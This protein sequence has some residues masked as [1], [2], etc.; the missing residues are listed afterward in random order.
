MDRSSQ[1]GT[2]TRTVAHAVTAA[3]YTPPC[4]NSPVP[5][6]TPFTSVEL[7]RW[8]HDDR[9]DSP[10]MLGAFLAYRDARTDDGEFKLPAETRAQLMDLYQIDHDMQ[11]TYTVAEQ[12]IRLGDQE[13]RVPQQLL[14]PTRVASVVPQVPCTA[15]N[16]RRCLTGQGGYQFRWYHP[17]WQVKY[18]ALRRPHAWSPTEGPETT[19]AVSAPLPRKKRSASC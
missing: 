2:R 8:L 4:A 6:T 10:A 11:P 12:T 19:W 9:V 13:M 15:Q 16:C 7:P 1:G 5:N 17:R 14:T 18:D 3:R